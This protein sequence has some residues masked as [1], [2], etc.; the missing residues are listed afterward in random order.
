MPL[1]YLPTSR[2]RL[3]EVP[4]Q[5]LLVLTCLEVLNLEHNRINRPPLDWR[6]QSSLRALLLA[7]NPLEYLPG[8]QPL[9][10]LV[11]LSVCN[12]KVSNLNP[13]PQYL[14]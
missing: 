11:Q 2:T 6:S 1:N 8:L 14:I 4:R 5:L 13:K 3:L 9:T 7:A 10:N 12:V